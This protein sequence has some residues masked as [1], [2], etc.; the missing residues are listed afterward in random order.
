MP[1]ATSPDDTHIPAAGEAP[2]EAGTASSPSEAGR[3]AK[4]PVWF[5]YLSLVGGCGV[6]SFGG[7]GLLLADIGHYRAWLALGL[8]AVGT[9]VAVVVGR[10]RLEGP[11]TRPAAGVTAPAV[12]ICLVAIAVALWN[13]IKI[14]HH[15]AVDTDPAVYAA[16]GHWIAGH[17]SLKV[18]AASAF[19]GLGMNFTLSSAGTY[20]VP[21]GFVEFQFAHLLPAL[22]AEGHSVGGDAVMFRIP[23]LLGAILLLPIYAVGCRLVRRPWIVVAALAALAVSLPQLSVTRDTYSEPATEALLWLGIWLL[24]RAYEERR[25]GVAL[26]SG[27]A[28]GGTLMTRIDANIYLAFLPPLALVAWLASRD[29]ADR[30]SLLRVYGAVLVG[31]LPAA[32]LGT[33]DVQRRAGYYYGSQRTQIIELYALLI[34]SVAGSLLVAWLW[35][36]L[37]SATRWLSERRRHLAAIGAWIIAIGLLLAWSIRPNAPKTTLGG[38]AGQA[39]AQ[40][41]QTEGLGAKPFSYAEQTMVWLNW[42]LGPVTLILAIAGLCFLTV[43]V[44]RHGSYSGLT[45]LLL[46]GPLTATYLW[47]PHITPYQMWAMRRFVPVSLPLLVLAAAVAVDS[48]ADVCAVRLRAPAWG[49]LAL[50]V[51]AAGMFVFALGPSIPVRSFQGQAGYT[52]LVNSTCSAVGKDAVLVFPDGDFDGVTLTQTLRDR[53]GIPAASL[54][55]MTPVTIAQLATVAQ[56]LRSRGQKL[57]VLG[58]SPQAIDAAVPGLNPTLVGSVRSPREL[59]HTI[60]RPPS[61]YQLTLLTVYAAKI[62]P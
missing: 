17:G 21:G 41:Q 32:L 19:S 8:G 45:V 24:L 47:N 49:R 4:T 53:C 42:Y 23:A 7:F 20:L 28:L 12:A 9:V 37:P 43:R 31:V 27:L 22:L 2:D 39:I 46:A 54:S 13:A 52:A 60:D 55:T 15:V 44:V 38:P 48:V 51:G 3:G 57:W 25:L 50:G 59:E 29:A 56:K 33:F 34:G 58:Y 18:P 1:S 36:R 35:P 40:L 11:K 16:A 10:P 6:L 5:D 61:H 62:S 30:R 26:V 14:S